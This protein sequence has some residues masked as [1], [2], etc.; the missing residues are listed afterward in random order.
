MFLL[1]LNELT[2]LLL[3]VARRKLRHIHV[4]TVIDQD[5]IVSIPIGHR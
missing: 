2:A 4:G 3:N 5:Y 1:I